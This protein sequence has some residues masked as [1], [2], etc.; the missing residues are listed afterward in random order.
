MS[1]I[2]SSLENPGR[3]LSGFNDSS[4]T[5][6]GDVILPVQVGPVILNVLFSVVEDLSPFN[7]ILGRTWLHGMK[8][9]P[10]T[11]HQM[12]SFITQDG[13]ID[14]YRSQLAARQC[15]QIA[16]EA[17]PSADPDPLETVQISEGGGRFAYVSTF[18]PPVERFELQ[19]VLQQNCD[20]FAWAHSDMSGILP[21][22]AS[23]RLNVLTTSKPVRQKIRRFHPDRQKVIQEEMK[24]L[25]EAGFIREVEYPEWLANVVVVPKKGGKWRVCVDYTNL[26]DACPKDS[27][28]LLRIDQ[29]VDATFG[30]ELLSFL[31]AFSGYHQIPMAPGDEEKTVFITPHRLYCY[32]VMSFGLKNA[33]ATYQRLMTKIFKPLIGDI[34]E[35]NPAKCAF[36]VSSGKFLGFMVTQRGIEIN[37]DQLPIGLLVRSYSVPC[38]RESKDPY[39]SSAKLLPM[40]R[41][42]LTNQPLRNVLHK[43]DI[44]GRMLRW[45]I[46]LSEYR[47]D[48]QPRLSL[49]GQVMADFIAELPEARISDKE[50]TP[51]DWWSLHVDEASRSSGSRVRLLLKAP[52]GE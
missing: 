2:P 16:R 30:H 44:T 24:K 10:S 8:A 36:G 48:Y 35:L 11:Y 32:R 47:K 29:I 49:K 22:V 25:L 3:T 52:T 1:F 28:P 23:H 17:G 21:S 45:A 19:K 41:Q 50:S 4:T 46:E 15:Y 18:L 9:I 51:D 31:D 39:I 5:S 26:N 13:Q 20:I 38:R 33:R 40:Q 34:V 14:L 27:F 43:P 37:P 7:A 6:L 12:V 42:V